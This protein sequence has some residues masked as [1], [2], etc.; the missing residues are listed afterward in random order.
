MDA[1]IFGPSSSG[2]LH[3]ACDISAAES[4]LRPSDLKRR[5][6]GEGKGPAIL[7]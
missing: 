4:R 6:G 7:N 5:G 3:E 2:G 1:D